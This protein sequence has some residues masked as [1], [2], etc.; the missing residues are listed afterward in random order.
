[1][2]LVFIIMIGFMLGAPATARSTDCAPGEGLI[3]TAPRD[4]AR[5]MNPS[6]TIRGYVC[7]NYPLITI[8]NRTTSLEVITETSEVCEGKVCTY[9]FAAPV[10]ELAL[11]ENLITAEVSGDEIVEIEVIRTALAGM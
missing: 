5:T 4:G 1:V 9:H 6:I 8:R 3:V 2:R 11:G 7:D 10:R